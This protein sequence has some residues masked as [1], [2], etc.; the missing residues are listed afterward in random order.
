MALRKTYY[1][2]ISDKIRI[3][4]VYDSDLDTSG[5]YYQPHTHDFVELTYVIEADGFHAPEDR[6]YKLKKHDL[7][8]TPPYTYHRMKLKPSSTYERYNLTIHSDFIKGIDITDIF[9]KINVIN[10]TSL[11]R[12]TDIFKKTDYYRENLND[13]QFE[14]IAVMLIKEI[15]YNL[16][17]LNHDDANAPYYVNAILSKAIDYINSNLSTIESVSE[18]SKHLYITDSY[19]FEIFKKHLKTSPKKYITEKRLYIAKNKISMGNKPSEVYTEVGFSDYAT[20]YRN[21][22]TLF[23]H[24]PSKEKWKN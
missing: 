2:Y 3:Q 15:F 16:S 10:C 22:V 17:I 5:K 8:I 23:G 12:I 24:S 1:T 6:E 13:S 21:Y 9:N 20:F 11:P 18:I 14:D 4:H 7:V 19:L